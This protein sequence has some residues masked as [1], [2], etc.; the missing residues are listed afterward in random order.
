MD[1]KDYELLYI[2]CI[3]VLKPQLTILRIM[4]CNK[5]EINAKIIYTNQLG[6]LINNAGRFL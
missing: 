2:V 4:H 6:I 5:S 3:N 1:K